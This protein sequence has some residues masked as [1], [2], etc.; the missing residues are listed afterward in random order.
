MTRVQRENMAA[1][2]DY[3]KPRRWHYWLAS[4]VV[5]GIA[6]CPAAIVPVVV[7]AGAW[8]AARSLRTSTK[9]FT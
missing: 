7:V 9:L 1:S 2:C 6:A 5:L 8:C 3:H 4:F